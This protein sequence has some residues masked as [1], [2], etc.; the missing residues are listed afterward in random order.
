MVVLKREN[1]L[2]YTLRE[3]MEFLYCNHCER[4]CILTMSMSSKKQEYLLIIILG[5]LLGLSACLGISLG[6]Q[7]YCF[8]LCKLLS[9]F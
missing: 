3:Y 6:Y 9:I 5:A 1:Y 7:M 2:I 4:I 8:A